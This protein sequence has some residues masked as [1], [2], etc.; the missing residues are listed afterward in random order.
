VLTPSVQ[1]VKARPTG[2]TSGATVGPDVSTKLPISSVIPAHEDVL[3][4]VQSRRIRATALQLE[5]GAADGGPVGVGFKDGRLCS[6][7]ASGYSDSEPQKIMSAIALVVL[8][9]TEPERSLS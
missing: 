2:Q 7:V 3:N 4:T 5:I 6:V 9:V 8:A 1:Q